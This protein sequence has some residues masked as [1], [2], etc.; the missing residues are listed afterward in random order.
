M[1]EQPDHKPAHWSWFDIVLVDAYTSFSS[2]AVS[3]SPPLITDWPICEEVA[4]SAQERGNC[5]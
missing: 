1:D 2:S 4:E 3:P 5:S